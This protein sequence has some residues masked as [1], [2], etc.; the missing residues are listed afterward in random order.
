MRRHFT[1]LAAE[2][3]AHPVDLPQ[4][5][6]T[7][8]THKLQG[9]AGTVGALRAVTFFQAADVDLFSATETG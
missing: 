9:E 7:F 1:H 6:F 5:E 4:G 8:P 2:R 3:T